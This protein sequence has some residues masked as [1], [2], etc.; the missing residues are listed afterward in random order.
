MARTQITTND[1]G[2]RVINA[3]GKR[4][5]TVSEVRNGTAYV[6]PD[7][8]ITESI[9]S[10]LGWGNADDDEYP[11]EARRVK[12]VTDDAIHLRN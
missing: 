8:G 11:L 2:K 10:R 9:R 5:G 3:K 7:S 12:K 6:D 4:I 1:E